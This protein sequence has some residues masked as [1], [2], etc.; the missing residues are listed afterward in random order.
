MGRTVAEMTLI[1]G[2]NA[3]TR[4]KGFTLLELV[5]VLVLISTVLAMAAPSLRGFVKGRQIAE[6]VAQ[7]LSL[8]HLARSQAASQG[9]VYRLNIDA[10]AK[11]YWLTMQR[12][13][14]FVELDSEHGRRFHLPE[15]VSVT[16]EFSVTNALTTY[17]QFY[18]DGRSDQV[19]I[20]LTGRGKKVFEVTCPSA[21][22]RFCVI[23]PSEAA[24]P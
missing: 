3:K 24:G 10:E 9:C 16:L 21:A 14:T 1:I 4:A 22:E 7:V 15:E 20:K 11:A 18:P 23:S 6:A 13:G 5:M 19:T 12:A 8:T 17:I 2:P